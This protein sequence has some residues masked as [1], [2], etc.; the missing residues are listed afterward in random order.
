MP[1]TRCNYIITRCN[2][3]KTTTDDINTIEGTWRGIKL[4]VPPKHRTKQ[5]MNGEL[6]VFCWRKKFPHNM[7]ERLLFAISKIV[8]VEKDTNVEKNQNFFDDLILK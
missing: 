5:F 3:T 8:Y 2:Y 4:K 6:M 1:I 7:R